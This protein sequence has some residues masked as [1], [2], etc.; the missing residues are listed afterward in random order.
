MQLIKTDDS[1][2]KEQRKKIF[3]GDRQLYNRKQK[4][5]RKLKFAQRNQWRE[6]NEQEAAKI[7]ADWRGDMEEGEVA[8]EG[9]EEEK[10]TTT[11]TTTK[12]DPPM[13]DAAPAIDDEFG[14]DD[15]GIF[16]DVDAAQ[17]EL[18]S[19]FGAAPADAPRDRRRTP[20]PIE[21]LF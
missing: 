3:E 13:A 19:G 15:G 11:T 21:D 18:L 10:K 20:S 9:G 14:D 4:E 2:T 7:A 17:D 6:R 5:M 8:G 12:S 1:L 16:E